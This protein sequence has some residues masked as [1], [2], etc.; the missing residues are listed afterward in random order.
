MEEK[1]ISSD[2][3]YRGNIIDVR[4]ETITLPEGKTG[5]REIV[6]HGD[7]IVVVPVD[8]DNQIILVRQY[9]KAL[10]NFLLEAPAGGIEKNETPG[11]AA[12]RE[13]QEE[14]GYTSYNIEYMG[15]FWIAPGFCNEYMY[16][17]IARDLVKSQLPPDEDEN[18]EIVSVPM[19]EILHLIRS[20]EIEDA[21]SISALL[22]ALNLF[23]LSL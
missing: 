12:V 18:I 10:E 16:S 8:K 3:V 14:I 5:Q 23:E 1:S 2:Y 21:K 13:L 7:S 6:D 11:D 20:G 4:L 19:E 22:M 15:G 17:Y 9:R